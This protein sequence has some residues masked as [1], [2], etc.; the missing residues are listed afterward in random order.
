MSERLVI[1]FKPHVLEAF[2]DGCKPHL[3]VLPKASSARIGG[4]L[5]NHLMAE[6]YL[7][8]CLDLVGDDDVAWEEAR[9]TFAQKLSLLGGKSGVLTELGILPGLRCLNRIR[10]QAAHDLKAQLT[11]TDVAPMRSFLTPH[12][13]KAR[14]TLP[15]EPEKVVDT[16]TAVA[17]ASLLGYVAAY[18]GARRL[19]AGSAKSK[20]KRPVSNPALKR[21]APSRRPRTLTR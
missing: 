6:H 18:R 21:P 13:Q 19:G 2:I 12:F 4:L 20:I 11:S 8:A 16:F 5:L 14:R 7:Q 3:R 9:L 10:N 17:C 15:A 1:A